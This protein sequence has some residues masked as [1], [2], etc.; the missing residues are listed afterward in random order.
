MACQNID[1]WI[2]RSV[3]IPPLPCFLQQGLNIV[4]V[5]ALMLQ[6]SEG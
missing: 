6:K 5:S 3:W 2:N 1:Q 4:D